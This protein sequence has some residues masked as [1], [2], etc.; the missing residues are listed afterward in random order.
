MHVIRDGRYA[1]EFLARF[2]SRRRRIVIAIVLAAA[3]GWA[4]A[5]FTHSNVVYYPHPPVLEYDPGTIYISRYLGKPLEESDDF[6]ADPAD[7]AS[8][9][10]LDRFYRVVAN[11]VK[12]AVGDPRTKYSVWICGIGACHGA[13]GWPFQSRVVS[14]RV[15]GYEMERFDGRAPGG[16]SMRVGEDG[17]D[18]DR[19][20]GGWGNA[21]VGSGASGFG[22]FGLL[23]LVV[24]W[25]RRI[26]RPIAGFQVIVQGQ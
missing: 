4:F 16:I 20:W 15:S 25:L 23:T 26:E 6:E 22:V 1:R 7:A 18:L 5:A 3:G 11:R 9:P 2:G 21:A 14:Y 19:P 24:M 12:A 10:N 8:Q 13:A 17:L